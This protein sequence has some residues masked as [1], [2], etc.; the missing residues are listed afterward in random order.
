MGC[1]VFR[2]L[3]TSKNQLTS[4]GTYII[5]LIPAEN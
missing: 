4:L 1:H 5:Y 2:V 3:T